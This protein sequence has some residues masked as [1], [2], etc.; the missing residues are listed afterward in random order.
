VLRVGIIGAGRVAQIAHLATLSQVAE[1]R[2]VSLADLRPELASLVAARWNIPRVYA[3]HRELLADPDVD[4]VVVVTQRSQT[5]AIVADALR[6]GKHVLSEK[7][8]ALS[9]V[10]ARALVQL[11]RERGLVY[12]VGYMKRH[13][14][15]IGVARDRIAQW[16]GDGAAGAM[17]LVRATM[18][19]GDDCAG[20][21]WLMTTEPRIDAGFTVTAAVGDPAPKS[22]FDQFLNVFSHTTNLARFLTNAPIELTSAEQGAGNA[23]VA[24]NLPECPFAGSFADRVV[25]GWHESVDVVF[26]RATVSVATPPP[27]DRSAAARVTIAHADGAIED[28][29]LP[30]WAFERQARAFVADAMHGSEPLAPGSD[31]VADVALGEA[32]WRLSERTGVLKSPPRR[33]DS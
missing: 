18:N 5:A 23:V 8:M 7:P 27:F 29:S 22:P 19:G 2:L 4:A 17:L 26:E 11:A 13:D 6:A 10:D 21:D 32:F 15:G 9:T 20:S 3:G 25:P 16:C 14:R 28:C 33:P 12:A 30:G 1:A 24:G 31:A